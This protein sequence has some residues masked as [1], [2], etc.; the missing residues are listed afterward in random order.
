MT[1]HNNSSRE[2]WLVGVQTKYSA[3]ILLNRLSQKD[4]ELVKMVDTGVGS[5]KLSQQ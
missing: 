3:H 5:Y 1:G 4:V 2:H